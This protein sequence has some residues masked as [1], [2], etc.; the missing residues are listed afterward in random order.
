MLRRLAQLALTASVIA[1]PIAATAAV[2]SVTNL[3]DAGPG[4][5]RQAVMDANA[6]AGPDQI[7][8]RVAGTIHL[9]SGEI[10][11]T[12]SL[13]ILGPGTRVLTIDSTNRIFSID[14]PTDSIDVVISDLTLADAHATGNGGAIANAGETVTLRFVTL[15]GNEATGEGG[16]IFNNGGILTIE[17]STL[18]N[19]RANKAGAI[20]TIGFTLNLINSTVS[21]NHASDSVGGIKFEFAFGSIS[22]STIADNDA[23][24]SQ[25]GILFGTGSQVLDILSSIVAGNTD[26]TGASDLARFAGFVN[27]T[28]SLFQQV[29]PGGAINGIDTDN[30]VGVDPL[31]SPLAAH[32]GPTDTH[33]LEPASPAIDR[34]VNLLGLAFDQRGPGF[35]RT[36]GA[37]TDIGAYERQPSSAMRAPVLSHAALAVM[38]LMLL[39]LGGRATVRRRH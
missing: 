25:G 12:D 16:A 31:L 38:S 24:F 29:L 18:S 23:T 17:N 14:N 33:A 15:S 10:A 21:G 32:G 4:S 26:I 39:V 37:A 34:G 22:N 36:I 2:F 6:T 35:P 30:L 3:N 27:A 8:V 1:C 7:V 11:I 19:N 20:Y 9:T 5:F 28:N 13:E